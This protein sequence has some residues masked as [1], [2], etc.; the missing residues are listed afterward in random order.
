MLFIFSTPLLIRHMWQLKTVLFFHWCL[1][2]AVLLPL[3]L[4]TGL[5][6]VTKLIFIFKIGEGVLLTPNSD[7]YNFYSRSAKSNKR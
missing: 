4:T 2:H 1:I 6:K 7:N 5:S 3:I